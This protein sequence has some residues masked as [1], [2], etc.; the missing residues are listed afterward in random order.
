M[1]KWFLMLLILCQ[2]LFPPA[3]GEAQPETLPP[4]VAESPVPA[5]AETENLPDLSA[6]S[7]EELM[8]LGQLLQAEM[9]SRGMNGTALLPGGTYVGGQDLPV[10]SYIISYDGL[11]DYPSGNLFLYSPNAGDEDDYRLYEFIHYSDAYSYYVRLN[12][13]DILT[14]PFPNTVEVYTGLNFQ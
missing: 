8:A 13:G 7:M 2:C 14:L 1:K 10:G 4:A 9:V 12:E 6:L 5:E 3:F 11:S